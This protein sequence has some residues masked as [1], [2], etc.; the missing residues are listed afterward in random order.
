MAAGRWVRAGLDGVDKPVWGLR[1]GIQV[2]L[3]PGTVEGVGDGGPRGLLR[4]GYPILDGGKRHGLVNF[5]AVEP[6]VGGRR[7]FSEV[8]RGADGKPGRLF[9]A[10]ASDAPTDKLHPGTLATADGGETLTITVH[11][12]TFDNGARVVL[13]LA[14]RSDRPG[15]LSITSRPAPGSARIEVCNLTATMGNYMRL[16]KLWLKDRV[17]EA[18]TV[19]PTFDG[20]E[21]APEAFFAADQLVRTPAGDVLVCATTDEADPHSVPPDP[22]APWWAYRGSFPLTQY[23]RVP[24]GQPTEGLRARVNGRK[25][26]WANHTPIPG[27]IAFENFDLMGPF[28][29]GQ[30]FV[31]GLS[32]RTPEELT[33]D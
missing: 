24:K 5:I 8:E 33:K 20:R 29:D 27:G 6:F 23:W 32:R 3:W 13:E 15:E 4:I 18:R 19:W 1:D 26:Y 21:F 22:A 10:G 9:W 16:R 14:I 7:G 11:T 2:A 25:L 17:V 12:E 30:T 28:R 31:F